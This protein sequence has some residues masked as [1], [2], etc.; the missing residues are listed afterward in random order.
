MSILGWIRGI[1]ALLANLLFGGISNNGNEAVEPYILKEETLEVVRNAL[2]HSRLAFWPDLQRD[3][4]TRVFANDIDKAHVRYEDGMCFVAFR[5]VYTDGL[6]DSLQ[7]APSLF[8]REVCGQAGCCNV[9]RRTA[10]AYYNSFVDELEA[11]VEE[12]HN[13]CDDGCDVVLTGF[14]QGGAIATIAAIALSQYNPILLTYAQ[15]PVTSGRCDVLDNMETYLRFTGSC[16]VLGKPAYD[17]ITYYGIPFLSRHSGTMIM[18]GHGGAA[19]VA[20]N[21]GRTFLPIRPQCHLMEDPYSLAI[22]TL[23]EAGPLDGFTD[24]SM[25]TQDIECQSQNCSGERCVA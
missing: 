22:D 11:A 8:P 16:E 7:S 20:K 10:K 18:L 5:G 4:D 13:R 12:C 14:S 9:H 23:M 17:S 6:A 2:Q 21:S 1:L 25:C 15:H 19:T 24:G 3:D